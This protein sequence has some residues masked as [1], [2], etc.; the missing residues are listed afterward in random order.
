MVA[1]A[2]V[3]TAV[4]LRGTPRGARPERLSAI[5]LESAGRAA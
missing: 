3:I 4:L 5:D 1:A 2:F